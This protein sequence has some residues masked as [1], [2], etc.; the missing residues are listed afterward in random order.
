MYNDKQ[1]EECIVKA[2]QTLKKMQIPLNSVTVPDTA[3]AM[4]EKK[5]SH[6]DAVDRIYNQINTMTLNG[7]IQSSS[8]Q[9]NTW[10]LLN[11]NQIRANS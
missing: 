4:L 11:N 3:I 8:D 2:F 5:I 6:D 10:N 9:I 7:K 1:A